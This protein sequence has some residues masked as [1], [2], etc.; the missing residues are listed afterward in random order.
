MHVLGVCLMESD[1]CACLLCLVILLLNQAHLRLFFVDLEEYYLF[2]VSDHSMTFDAS[3]LTVSDK[4]SELS[5]LSLSLYL[6]VCLCVYFDV[7]L[8][9]YG[10]AQL[11]FLHTCHAK[12]IIYL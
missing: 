12:A 8:I 7:S 6:Y 2:S 3:S 10:H 9:F 1:V 4:M 11:M 5:S